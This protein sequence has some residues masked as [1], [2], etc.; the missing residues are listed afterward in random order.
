ML[1]VLSWKPDKVWMG[2]IFFQQL[3][4]EINRKDSSCLIN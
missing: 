3:T 2:S 1:F 4:G